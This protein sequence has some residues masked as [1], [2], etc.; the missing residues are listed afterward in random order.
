MGNNQVAIIIPCY[1]EENRLRVDQ[2]HSFLALCQH[3][4]LYMLNDGSTDGTLPLLQTLAQEIPSS[5][6]IRDL[7]HNMGKAEV[8]RQG[9]HMLCGQT[10]YQYIGFIDA[11][12]SAPLTELL[13][14]IEKIEQR[15][16]LMIAGSRVKLLGRDINRSMFRH[17]FGRIFATYYSSILQLPNYDTQCGLKI[18]ETEFASKLFAEQFASNWFFDIEL[19]VRARIILG[20]EQYALQIAE[21]PLQEWR[22]VGGSKLKLSDFLKAPFEVLKIYSKY[23]S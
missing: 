19:F 8:I 1:N 5:I 11:D 14:L 9:M 15:K 6:F 17:Y 13:P 18:F 3:I 7:E 20:K 4:D 21:E 12:F 16:L 22:E 23:K 10:K 2:I